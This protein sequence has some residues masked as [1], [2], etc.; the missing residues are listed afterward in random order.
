MKRKKKGRGA[1]CSW[2]IK[3]VIEGNMEGGEA[4]KWRESV[5][6]VREKRRRV[7]EG[8]RG[9]EGEERKERKEEGK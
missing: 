5:G 6:K 7:E 1:I 8:K 2:S 4:G 9:R 3:R